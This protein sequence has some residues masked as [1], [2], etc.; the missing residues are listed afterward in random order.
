MDGQAKTHAFYDQPPAHVLGIKS[1]SHRFLRRGL[2]YVTLGVTLTT[3][4]K[5]GSGRL[6]Q[7]VL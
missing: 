2:T 3:D 1:N 5:F 6:Y 7:I 4:N